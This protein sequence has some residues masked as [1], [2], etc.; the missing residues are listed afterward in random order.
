VA[1]RP[2][3]QERGRVIDPRARVHPTADLEDNVTVGPRS[4]IWNDAVV[5]TGA[6]IGADCV[7]GRTAFIDEGVVLGDRVKVQNG[8]LV[9]H[10]ATVEDGVFIGPGAIVTN[11]LRPRAETPE[12]T[13]ARAADWTVTATEL[14]RGSSLGAGAI[15]VAGCHLGRYSMVGAGSVV[16][17][18]VP[19]HA[20]V[21]GNPAR[22]LG[23]VC[24]CG[25][26]L[27][28]RGDTYVCGSCA[29]AYGRNGDAGLAELQPAASETRA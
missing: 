22:L 25:Q 18:P 15:V 11:D 12:G 9:Y 20:L 16:T 3:L 2:E 14:R 23:W 13:L 17:K 28:E 4:A 5:R 27:D 21:V 24:A 7:I 6:R 8:A 10:G 26:R 19:D 29:R 1:A